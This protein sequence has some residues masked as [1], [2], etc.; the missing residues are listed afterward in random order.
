MLTAG[1][2]FCL[3]S[4]N[5]LFKTM[6]KTLSLF[7]IAICIASSGAAFAANPFIPSGMKNTNVQIEEVKQIQDVVHNFYLRFYGVDYVLPENEIVPE[8]KNANVYSLTEGQTRVTGKTTR[9]ARIIRGQMIVD[10]L[11]WDCVKNGNC[12]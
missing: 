9:P 6:K 1:H 3:F 2:Y 10:N 8:R 12:N 11:T 7:A 5:F 4:L